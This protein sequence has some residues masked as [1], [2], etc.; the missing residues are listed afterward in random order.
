MLDGGY[1]EGEQRQSG[2]REGGGGAVEAQVQWLIRAM[3]CG[4]EEPKINL[5]SLISPN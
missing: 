1:K 3:A 2:D 4:P 5:P